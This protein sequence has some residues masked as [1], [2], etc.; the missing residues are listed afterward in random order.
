MTSSLLP[1]R[2]AHRAGGLLCTLF[3]VLTASSVSAQTLYTCKDASGRTLSSDRPIPECSDRMVRE[4]NKDG[5][6]KREIQPELMGEARKRQELE[7][8]QT[9][10]LERQ[11]REQLRR[12]R[13][14]LETYQSESDITRA[15][16]RALGLSEDIIQ[17]AQKRLEQLN[18]RRNELKT[19]G[20]SGAGSGGS[21]AAD[22]ERA[23]GLE[24]D[25]IQ[26][27]RQEMQRINERFDQE[28]LRFRE[29]S[30]A[31]DKPPAALA[32][33]AS[34]AGNPS[35]NAKT[36]PRPTPPLRPAPPALGLQ[37]QTAQ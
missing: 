5:S 24:Q 30:G 31:P 13:A 37:Q 33:T 12:D 23:V 1:P 16:T 8:R 2:P 29:L 19:A 21:Q 35:G 14:I 28:T 20:R 15:R 11:R 36:L 17:A 4:L 7:A 3:T 9:A 32:P 27:Q 25:L 34:A 6:L 26:R 10:E 18:Q 22:V